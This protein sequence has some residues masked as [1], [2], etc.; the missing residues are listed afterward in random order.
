M[1]S[2]IPFKAGADI[3]CTRFNESSQVHFLGA[4]TPPSKSHWSFQTSKYF[5]LELS[6]LQA[7]LLEAFNPVSIFYL[8]LKT[9]QAKMLGAFEPPSKFTWRIQTCNKFTWRFQTCNKFTWRFQTSK[10]FSFGGFIPPSICAWR[11]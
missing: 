1:F 4:V 5:S 6:T 9:L 8:E 7:S 11:F 2:Q 10:H 3:T